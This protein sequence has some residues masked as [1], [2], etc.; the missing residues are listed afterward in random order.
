M[1]KKQAEA[2]FKIANSNADLSQVDDSTLF[3][4][5]LSE[6]KPTYTTLEAVAKMMRWQA[7]KF[8]GNWD[9]EALHELTVI[10][11]KKFLILG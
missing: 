1:T 9:M 6:F 11:R 8:N 7:Q 4:C 2:A 5:G 3:G 10:G